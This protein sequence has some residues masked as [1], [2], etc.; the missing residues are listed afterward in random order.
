MSD[1]MNWG[2]EAEKND[3]P[4]MDEGVH[5]M[6][7]DAW[8]R[9]ESSK[10]KSP[11]IEWDYSVH[12]LD[13]PLGGKP[14]KDFF[15]LSAAALWRLAAFVKAV[16]IDMAKLPEMVVGAE[17]FN[18]VLEMCK[19]RK[20]YVHIVHE[21]YDGKTRHKVKE[22]LPYDEQGPAPEWG[23]QAVPSFIKA[24]TLAKKAGLV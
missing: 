19:G 6:Q 7:A 20:F 9:G 22:Y 1:T 8:V 4:L 18:R 5:L 23:E 3:Y 21:V 2:K 10:S 13:N 16:G 17:E 24:K 12:E 11:Q 15:S 14:F